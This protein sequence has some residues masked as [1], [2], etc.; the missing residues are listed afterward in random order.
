MSSNILQQSVIDKSSALD[1]IFGFLHLAQRRGAFSFA[2]SAKIFECFQQFN[3]FFEQDE[4]SQEDS[5]IPEENNES[6]QNLK[7]ESLGNFEE[8]DE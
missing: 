5:S 4:P 8:D 6:N 2:E 7:V 1:L 3:D